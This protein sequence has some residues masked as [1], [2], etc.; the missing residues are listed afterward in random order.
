MTSRLL[1][2]LMQAVTDVGLEYH[3]CLDKLHRGSFLILFGAPIQAPAEEQIQS[4]INFAHSLQ[5]RF[6][7][8]RDSWPAV[9]GWRPG[10]AIGIHHGPALV[11]V[12]GGK[13]RADY[14]AIGQTVNLAARIEGEAKSGEI[15]VSEKVA[16]IL[17]GE[18]CRPLGDV[19]LKG[20]SKPQKLFTV[21]TGLLVK[22]EV[23]PAA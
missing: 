21:D 19:R 1:E 13:R 7:Q 18:A 11:G 16:G 4:A 12:F 15:M 22:K 23:P 14:T 2:S 6:N 3:G 9:E 5:L 10:L 20:I 8:I 17:H